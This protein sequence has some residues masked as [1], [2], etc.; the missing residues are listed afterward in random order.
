[1]TASSGTEMLQIILRTIHFSSK[2]LW[3]IHCLLKMI[4]YLAVEAATIWPEEFL[5]IPPG[6]DNMFV[7]EPKYE[8]HDDGWWSWCGNENQVRKRNIV[9]LFVIKGILHQKICYR[10]NLIFWI[11]MGCGIQMGPRGTAPNDKS[12]KSFISG[13]APQNPMAPPLEIPWRRPSKPLR[14]PSKPHGAVPRNPW[15]QNV[16][17]KFSSFG[18][19]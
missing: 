14:R 9:S 4:L 7:F 1:M 13:A 2:S 11:V 5:W 6:K 3:K 15:G 16:R 19:F 17:P 12:L 8:I 18:A 10:L